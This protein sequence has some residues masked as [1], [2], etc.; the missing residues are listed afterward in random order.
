MKRKLLII[1]TV[2]I[3]VSAVSCRSN[4]SRNACVRFSLDGNMAI[5]DAVKSTLS[6]FTVVPT[7]DDFTLCVKDATGGKIWEGK[8][9]E[10]RESNILPA[11]NYVVS[12]SYGSKDVEGR[13]CPCL[14]GSANF[15]LNGGDQL[16]V[17]VTVSLANAIV[18]LSVTD[19]FRK[20]YP[21][22]TVNITTGGGTLFS[23]N[24]Q[25]QPYSIF[26]DPFKFSLEGT[27]KS[28]G[29]VSSDIPAKEYASIQKAT[30][31]ILTMDASNVGGSVISISFNDEVD[32]VDLG[33]INLN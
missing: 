26:M 5:T 25:T 16:T 33:E 21:E 19:A 11:G 7:P 32:T 15:A 20:Y 6:D 9:P 3:A 12:A 29:G 10:W 13:D 14:E 27:L 17:P 23:F 8:Y 1:F 4:L 2:I 28:Q 24:E 30:C 18:R 22:Y 31:Y